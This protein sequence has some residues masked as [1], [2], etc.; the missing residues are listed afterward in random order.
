[1]GRY[2]TL[3]QVGAVFTNC[4]FPEF[5]RR[6]LGSVR[7]RY[8]GIEAV[9]VD[10]GCVSPGEE[11]V[12][13]GREFGVPVLRNDERVGTGRSIDRGLRAL[14]RPLFLT[15]DH[16]VE[17]RDGGMVEILLDGM[18]EPEVFGVGRYRNDK[19]CNRA[20]GPYVDPVFALW[21]REFIL[22]HDDLS[23]KLTFIRIGEWQVAGCSTAQ[24]LQYRAMRLGAKIAPI[25]LGEFE[26]HVR[27]H[28]TPHTRGRTASPHEL[29]VV[30]ED[31]LIPRRRRPDGSLVY[32]GDKR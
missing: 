1:M 27:H 20:F 16:G 5:T 18:I 9:I 29:V 6:A 14:T 28:R 24:F 25:R 31:Y 10:D 12:G 22:A 13:V 2:F 32:P 30:D 4:L 3:D 19:R 21:D 11:I 17:L 23:F 8:P 7:E 15:V 26:R